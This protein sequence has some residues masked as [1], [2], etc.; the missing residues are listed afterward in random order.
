MLTYK[1]VIKNSVTISNPPIAKVKLLGQMLTHSRKQGVVQ[2]NASLYN[3][4]TT[5]G[6]Y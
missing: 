6:G 1:L 5:I 4:A 3:C 2:G